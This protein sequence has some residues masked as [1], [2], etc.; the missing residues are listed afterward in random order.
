MLGSNRVL[1]G[2]GLFLRPQHFQQQALFL[3]TSIAENL[4]QAQS[5]PWGVRHASLDSEALKG[6][7][8]RLH[9]LELVF[10]DGT[11]VDVPK[12]GP[13]PLTRNLEDISGI[14]NHT[15]VYACVPELNA[16]GG[17]CTD[18]DGTA[19]RPSR[20]LTS[21]SQTADLYTDALETDV[22]ILHAN[23]R[24]MVEEENRDG[25]SSVALCRITKNANGAWSIEP[26]FIPPLVEIAG[27]TH[28]Q[29]MLRRLLDILLV[30]ST[31]LAARHRE[32]VKSVVEYGTSDIASFWLLHTVNRTFPLFNHFV[33]TPTHP[34]Y[35]YT[36][37]AQFCGELMTFSS[38]LT[39]KDIPTY[40]HESLT[41]VF[42]RLDTIIRELL[43]TV[44][45]NRYT[46]I[47][48]DNARPS[49][50]VGRL[51]SERLVEDVDYYLSISSDLPAA[52][53]LEMAPL[54]LK[55]GS[56]DDVE[57]I[58][59]SALPGVRLVHAAQTPSALPVRVGNHYFILE[60]QGQI[61]DRM[62]QARS[63]CIY[64]PQALLEFKLELFAVFR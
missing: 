48:L 8:L 30:K 7:T 1:W 19:P 54:K 50:Y 41:A 13:L 34:E 52:H 42:D 35:L 63:I 18:G 64:V 61:F 6:G 33:L 58:L 9:T 2:E 25:H 17:N 11:R 45:S 38:A 27:C 29:T 37:M 55:A 51:D 14:G 46:I 16:F 10:R 20:Y 23:V 56:P 5:F 26:G 15:T 43:E 60:P 62:R 40:C 3:E 24:L 31:A 44:V 21:R 53:V 59:N 39:L 28:L 36:S 57:K 32:R 49:F 22:T 12:D 4:R 47:P